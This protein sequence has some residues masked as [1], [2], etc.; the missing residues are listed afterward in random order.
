M[1]NVI[2]DI[3]NENNI[4]GK[5]SFGTVYYSPKY[6]PQYIVKKME[7]YNTQNSSNTQ[8]SSIISNNIKELWWYSLIKHFNTSKYTYLNIPNLHEYYINDDCIYLLL[9]YKGESIHHK[10]KKLNIKGSCSK[11][12]SCSHFDTV[13]YIELLKNIPLII[14]S[15]SKIFQY[16]H[17]ADL[18]HGDITIYNIMYNNNDINEL[19][20][21]SIIDWGSFVFTKLIINNYNQCTPG[22]ISPELHEQDTHENLTKPSIKSDIFSLG[23]VILRILDPFND[24]YLKIN[25]YIKKYEISEVQYDVIPNIIKNIK[26]KISTYNI[27]LENYLDERVFYLL[28]KMLELNI[29]NRIDSDSLYMDCLFEKYRKQEP[30]FD[31]F[32]LKNILRNEIDSCI[33]YNIQV[34]NLKNILVENTYEYLKR[35]KFKIIKNFIEFKYVDTRIILTPVMKLFYNY[36]NKLNNLSDTISNEKLSKEHVPNILNVNYVISFLCCLKWIDVLFNNDI[37]IYDLFDFYRFLYK[38][39]SN[40]IHSDKYKILNSVEFF[41]FFDIT[42]YNIFNILDGSVLTYPYVLDFKYDF[43]VYRDIKKILLNLNCI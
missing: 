25:E 35:F 10:I 4:I 42:F 20:K 39:I 30:N 6:Y 41:I 32:Y 1:N 9:D 18:R 2:F 27:I 28:T 15:C 40:D 21:I 7:K 19:E 16:L 17:Y 24:H 5:G 13:Q 3:V 34:D 12:S 33:V 26:D 38:I 29:C 23:L 14:Y 37:P 36:L 11:L 8:S 22:F 43:I 31:K